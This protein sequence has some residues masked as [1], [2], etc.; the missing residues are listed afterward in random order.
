ME[1]SRDYKG[2]EITNK[3]TTRIELR[4]DLQVAKKKIRPRAR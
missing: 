1:R 4:Q 3:S 2:K